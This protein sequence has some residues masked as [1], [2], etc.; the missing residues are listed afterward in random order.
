VIYAGS[1]KDGERFLGL[2]D[3]QVDFDPAALPADEAARADLGRHID[4][5]VFGEWMLPQQINWP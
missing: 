4:T 3:G 1:L 2:Y 5:T